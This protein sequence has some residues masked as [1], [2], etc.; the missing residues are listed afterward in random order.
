MFLCFACNWPLGCSVRTK[1]TK[2]VF[3]I[4]IFVVV[5]VVVV[6]FK[7]QVMLTTFLGQIM[8][9]RI[10]FVIANSVTR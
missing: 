6:S 8:S 9:L 7:V 2:I 3:I 4:I 1:I 10:V 5:V